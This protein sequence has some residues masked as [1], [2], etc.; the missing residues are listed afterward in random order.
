MLTGGLIRALFND[1]I[2]FLNESRCLNRRNR[3]E[4]CN[5]CEEICTLRA[6][7]I[8]AGLPVI[9]AKNCDSC[10]LCASVCPS[11][12]LTLRDYK[13]FRDLAV[14]DIAKC[15]NCGGIYCFKALSP[16]L[17]AAVILVNP[18]INFV[19]P[20]DNCELDKKISGKNLDTALNF[21]DSFGILHNI[22]ITRDENFE[23]ELSR[24]DLLAS[25]FTLGKNK[26]SNI[27][28]DVF[29][30]T[31]NDIFLA[32]KFLIDRLNNFN[33]EIESGVFYNFTVSENCNICGLCEGL[34]PSK[35]W[36][37]EKKN[38][39]AQL[40]F[41]IE[42]CTGCMLCVKK[43]PVSAINLR[44]K[45]SW[46]PE[47]ELKHEINMTRCRHCGM[48][49]IKSKPDQELCISCAGHK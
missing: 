27:L 35:S 41:Y 23:N 48:Y 17:L 32:R 40:K 38:G 49:F 11:E 31:K 12:A 44:E 16:E 21:L 46:P 8:N 19:M 6:L 7:N 26:S 43:C 13:I 3:F 36:Q 24:R 1:T 10:G 25:F 33:G 47:S 4:P 45:I 29:M 20:C 15:K 37:I 30:H 34:C 18:D 42:N 2:P 9:N 14:N 39:R 28:E 5:L 22:T